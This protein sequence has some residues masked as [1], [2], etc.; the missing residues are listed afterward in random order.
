MPDGTGFV[1]IGFM[2]RGDEGRRGGRRG[3]VGRKLGFVSGAGL[4]LAAAFTLA[5]ATAAATPTT[6][7]PTLP[8]LC[9]FGARRAFGHRRIG[10]KAG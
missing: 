6:T 9:R 7:L 5:A 1:R 2:D 3:L 4:G 10:G 8:T